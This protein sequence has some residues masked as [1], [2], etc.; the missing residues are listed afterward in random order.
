[1]NLA[2][3]SAVGGRAIKNDDKDVVV[4]DEQWVMWPQFTFSFSGIDSDSWNLN[5]L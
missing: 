4:A 1:M 3:T 5:V 2:L